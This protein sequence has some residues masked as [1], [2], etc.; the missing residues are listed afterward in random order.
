MLEI[1]VMEIIWGR[2]E[3][4]KFSCLRNNIEH[5]FTESCDSGSAREGP[6]QFAKISCLGQF[7]LPQQLLTW[8]W[9]KKADPGETVR[10]KTKEMQSNTHTSVVL[11]DHCHLQIIEE[12]L[13]TYI[14]RAK[15]HCVFRT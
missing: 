5:Q 13:E 1:R 11:I 14:E 3:G 10:T 2:L 8:L 7:S 6:R 9:V 12:L 15:I 4:L